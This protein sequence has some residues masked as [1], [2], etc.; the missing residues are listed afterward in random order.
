VED[1]VHAAANATVASR[2]TCATRIPFV[3]TIMTSLK[4]RCGILP[5]VIATA[6]VP[7]DSRSPFQARPGTVASTTELWEGGAVHETLM[8]RCLA[9]ASSAGDSGE[10]A[11]GALVVRGDSVIAEGSECTRRLFDPSAHA[12]VVALRAACQR[13]RTLVL[14]GCELYTT[15]EPCVLCSYAIRRTGIVRVVYGISAGQAGGATSKYSLLTDKELVG[16]SPPPDIVSGVLEHECLELLRRHARA[17]N[18]SID[19]YNERR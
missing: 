17:R 8:R 15:V 18:Y 13:E 11:V 16:C 9:L 7:R 10:T 6:R 14:S 4:G 5:R 12:E 1:A 3:R 19:R 2:P